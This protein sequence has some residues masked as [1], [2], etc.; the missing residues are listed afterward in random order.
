MKIKKSDIKAAS[1]VFEEY[2]KDK[3]GFI[4]KSEF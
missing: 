2:D 1:K 3:N 4:D